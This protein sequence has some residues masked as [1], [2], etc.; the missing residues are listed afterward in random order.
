MWGS[1][2]V[3]K[4]TQTTRT[5]ALQALSPGDQSGEEKIR[6][7]V[8]SIKCHQ[9]TSHFSTMS[10][11]GVLATRGRAQ[12][13]YDPHDAMREELVQACRALTLRSLQRGT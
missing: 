10:G 2:W 3:S 13:P 8:S 1:K 9:K 12:Q 11:A 7:A 4:S 6:G 5:S